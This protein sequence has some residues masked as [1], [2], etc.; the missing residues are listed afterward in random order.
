M[1]KQQ[2]PPNVAIIGA[3]PSGLAAAKNL[4][5]N[6]IP[7]TLYEAGSRVGGQWVLESDSGMSAA[8][9]SLQTNPHTGMCRYSDFAFPADYPPYPEH[10]EMAQW[11]HSYA[12]HF[13]LLCD[14]RFGAQVKTAEPAPEGGYQLLLESGETIQHD[15]LIVAAGNLWDPKL[16]R[17]P[18]NF[19]GQIIHAKDYLDVIHPIDCRGKRVLVVGLGNTACELAVELSSTGGASKVLLSARSGQNVIPKKVVPL[20][21]PSEPLSGLFATLPPRLRDGLFH[22]LMPRMLNKVF[23]S[24]PDPV[25]LGLPPRPVN[26]FEKRIVTNSHIYD[27]LQQGSVT[28]KPGIRRLADS[29]VEFEDDSSEDVDIIISA[30]GYRF[31]LPFLSQDLLGCTPEKLSLYRGLMHP[32]RHD[33]FVIGVMKAVCSIWPRAEQQAAFIAP[34]LLGEYQLPKQHIIDRDSYPMLEVPFSNCQFYTHD[35]RLETRR[36]RQRAKRANR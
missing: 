29:A 5:Q 11:F 24:Q 4:K 15:A 17:W 12:E 34:L 23:A 33:L 22:F 1:K 35:L 14:I 9:R 10:A 21:H 26:F 18:G 19:S 32:T 36:G 2:T 3:G 20:P 25:S 30:T 28:A 27:R 13:D 6:G 7:Y 16:P 31:S 8:Y